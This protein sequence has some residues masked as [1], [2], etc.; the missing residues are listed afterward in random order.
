VRNRADLLFQDACML[1]GNAA[2][3]FEI[4]EACS[5]GAIDPDLAQEHRI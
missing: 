3:A 5:M 2:Q 4:Q 1:Y